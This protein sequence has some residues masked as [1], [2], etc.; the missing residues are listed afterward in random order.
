MYLSIADVQRIVNAV[1]EET[2]NNEEF[3]ALALSNVE[4][5]IRLIIERDF[6]K[7]VQ[8]RYF[9]TIDHYKKNGPGWWM[10]R[11]KNIDAYAG[12]TGNHVMTEGSAP[13]K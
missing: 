1:I 13:K 8:A 4:R 6:P 10:T 12:T 9:H 3:K 2:E 11:I 7:E 5:A